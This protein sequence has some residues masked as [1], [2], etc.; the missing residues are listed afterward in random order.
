MGFDEFIHHS[1][2]LA[3]RLDTLVYLLLVLFQVVLYC[4]HLL[5]LSFGLLLV[6]V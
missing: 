3:L 1:H 6:L 2:E 4:D 5:F